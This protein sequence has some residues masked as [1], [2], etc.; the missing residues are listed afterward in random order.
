[1]S[2]K[3]ARSLRKGQSRFARTRSNCQSRQQPSPWCQSVRLFFYR[4]PVL[5]D[6]VSTWSCMPKF[7]LKALLHLLVKAMCK[8]SSRTFTRKI[9]QGIDTLVAFIRILLYDIT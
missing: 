9:S 1:M 7:S 8:I 4:S 2:G 3:A 6:L 5:R